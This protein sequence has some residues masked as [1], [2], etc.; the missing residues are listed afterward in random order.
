LV[1]HSVV[2]SQK[3]DGTALCVYHEG[4][5]GLNEVFAFDQN[6]ASWERSSE[7]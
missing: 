4:V 1:V 2:S 3:D 5:T 6:E 7:F